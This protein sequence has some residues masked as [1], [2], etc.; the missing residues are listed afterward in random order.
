MELDR[1]DTRRI[2]RHS[3]V[4]FSIDF[5]R[6]GYRF[7]FLI[8]IPIF[9]IFF[10][11]LFSFAF[12]PE[13]KNSRSTIMNLASA[14]LASLLAYRFVINNM[15]P[16]GVGYFML[17]DHIFNLFLV[18]SFIELCVAISLVCYQKET[19]FVIIGRGLLFIFFHLASLIV[20]YYLLFLW[21]K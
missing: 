17:S 16:S 5:K 12:N 3:K 21:I 11:G 14:S 18:L 20:W 10:I 8:F 2:V 9:L 7:I 13:D 15:A 19:D 4:I 1:H 6:S